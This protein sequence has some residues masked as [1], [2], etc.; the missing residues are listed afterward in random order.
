MHS[1]KNIIF[2][3][4]L[5][6]IVAW[7]VIQIT[8]P[9][10]HAKKTTKETAFDRVMR[11]GTIRCGY[12]LTKEF[13]SRDEKTGKLSGAGYDMIEAIAKNLSLKVEWSAEVGLASMA[14]DLRQG[15]FDMICVPVTANAARARVL[16]F[17]NPV[18]L[19]PI[20]AWVKASD[21]RVGDDLSWINNEKI[22]VSSIDGIAFEPI[23]KRVFPK[24]KIVSLPEMSPIS[25]MLMNVPAG[26][27]DVVL[28]TPVGGDFFAMS[29]PGSIKYA[30]KTPVSMQPGAFPLPQ[31][32][33][34]LATMINITVD[35]MAYNGTL[36]AI[37]NRYESKPPSYYWS[38]RQII[39]PGQ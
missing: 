25:D 20:Y 12:F 32:D 38:S 7:G 1:F 14:E 16:N 31:G 30:S 24:A 35:E 39:K 37:L 11:T 13:L 8:T 5:S 36:K 4:L 29:N 34:K 22:R 28:M 27:A 18:F 33:V 21:P 23:I 6:T 17:S 3:I 19:L 15:R 2:T 26:K 10:T 9:D